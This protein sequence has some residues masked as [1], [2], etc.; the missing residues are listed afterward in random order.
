MHPTNRK[1][2]KPMGET[3]RRLGLPAVLGVVAVVFAAAVLWAAS[4][5]AAGGSASGEGDGGTRDSPAAQNV[6]SEG[7]GRGDCPER[8]GESDPASAEA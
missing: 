1:E 3:K 7:E 6:Q 4:A 5:L 2:V 8:D